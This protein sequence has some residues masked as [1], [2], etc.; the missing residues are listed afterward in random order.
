MVGLLLRAADQREHPYLFRISPN[1]NGRRSTLRF[2]SGRRRG[3]LA[4]RSTPLTD[5]ELLE[6]G[7]KRPIV[8]VIDVVHV[9]ETALADVFVGSMPAEPLDRR[10][11]ECCRRA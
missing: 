8:G 6:Y 2:N 1:G 7:Q 3:R 9:P 10:R 5:R 4:E 11:I